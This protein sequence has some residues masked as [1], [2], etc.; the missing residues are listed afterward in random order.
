MPSSS[1]SRRAERNVRLDPMG[2]Y[3]TRSERRRQ[4]LQRRRQIQ[5][6]VLWLLGI[7]AIGFGFWWVFQ[8]HPTLLRTRWSKEMPFRPATAPVSTESG[9]VLLASQSGGL[10][11]LPQVGGDANPRRLFATA[12]APMATPLVVSQ[13]AF[14][15]GGDGVLR[16]LDLSGKARWARALP[17]AL[18]TRP[19]L[20]R[21]QSRPIVAV[22][23]DEGNVAGFDAVTGQPLW[24]RRLGGAAGEAVAVFGGASPAFIVPTLAGATSGGGLV[25]LDAATGAPR[26][27]FPVNPNEPCPGIAAPAVVE[28]KVYWCND[29]GTVIALDAAR[30]RKIWKIYAK[31]KIAAK[32]AGKEPET[33]ISLRGAP[34]VVQ[35]DR[36]VAVGGN[37]GLLRAYDTETGDQRW[38]FDV[39]GPV[40]H[41]PERVSL[42]GTEALLVSGGAPGIFLV[43]A[44]SGRVLRHW[45]TPYGTDL[46]V[47]VASGMALAL[48][49][50]GHL[51]GA[52]IR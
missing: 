18:V 4:Q 31:P 30:G 43:E 13:T 5:N 6:I 17:S 26:W 34:V 51:Q 52:A 50:E 40:L 1:S 7:A 14:W 3:G 46:G 41:A 48:D 35:N 20:A 10:W 28:G 49:A 37:D 22:G 16:A 12:F 11:S 19:G 36:V 21:T 15:P 45:T 9:Q 38:V 44:S 32:E 29:E 8:P 42:D 47:A 23:D 27:R 2:I 33:F 24:T 39:G 25:C